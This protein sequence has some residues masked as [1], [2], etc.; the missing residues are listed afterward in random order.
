MIRPLAVFGIPPRPSAFPRAT[1]GWPDLQREGAVE[2]DPAQVRRIRQ[3]ENRD[4]PRDR[5]AD[6][7]CRV[8]AVGRDVDDLEARRPADHVVVRQNLARAGDD[9]PG[10]GRETALVAELG[11][12]VDDAGV[13][14]GLHPGVQGVPGGAGRRGGYGRRQR[15]QDGE[16]EAS[17]QSG[18]VSIRAS[19]DVAELRDLKAGC[20]RT[21]GPWFGQNPADL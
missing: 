19:I 7:G 17:R 14:P 13:R 2:L 21:C 3:L 12:D 6:H 1:T 4:V 10:A 16:Q 20:K 8:P 18:H 5:I 11:V 15:R 9:H